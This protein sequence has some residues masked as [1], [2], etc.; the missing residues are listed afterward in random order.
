M[1]NDKKNGEVNKENEPMSS[2]E[3]MTSKEAYQRS[4]LVMLEIRAKMK[5]QNDIDFETSTPNITQED[6]KKDL[7]YDKNEHL[8]KNTNNEDSKEVKKRWWSFK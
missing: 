2:Q 1:G 6:S 7:L 5:K 3:P 4:R 8:N